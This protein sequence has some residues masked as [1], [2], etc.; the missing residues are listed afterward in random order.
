MG[1]A[2]VRNAV[3]NNPVVQIGLLGVLGVRQT[4]QDVLYDGK[5]LSYPP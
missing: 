4:V 5:Q 2:D 3:N 1:R